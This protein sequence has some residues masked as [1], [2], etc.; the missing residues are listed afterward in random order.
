MFKTFL[1]Y[2]LA[3]RERLHALR[4]GDLQMEAS[5]KRSIMSTI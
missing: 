4:S 3:E 1:V 5:L 2:T